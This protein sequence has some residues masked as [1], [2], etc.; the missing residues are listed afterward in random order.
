[1]V[2]HRIVSGFV[3]QAGE[4]TAA[5]ANINVPQINNEIVSSLRYTSDGVL[6][7]ARTNNDDTNNSQF[8]ITADTEPFLDYQYTIFGRVVSDPNNL[9]QAMNSVPVDSNSVP[10]SAVTITDAKI[11]QD[12]FDEALQIGVPFGVSSGSGDITVT[13]NDGNGGT[14]SQ[15]F[16]VTIQADQNDPSAFLQNVPNSVTTTANTPTTFQ[17]STFDLHGDTLTYYGPSGLQSS[18]FSN[19]DLSPS[20]TL[21]PNVQ[22]NVNSSTGQVTVTPTNGFVGVAPLWVG[23][24]STTA[25]N[26]EPSTAMIPLFV[27]PAAPSG[28]SLASSSDTG[29]SNSDG[30]TANNNS[31]ASTELSFNVSGVTAGDTIELFDGSTQIFSMVAPSASFTL[32][33]DGSHTLTGR[34]SFVFHQASRARLASRIT[35]SATPAAR[36]CW[37]VRRPPLYL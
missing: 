37:P 20:Q 25:L 16:H 26:T 34:G 5:D 8:F 31:S 3:D 2:F 6:G 36:R 12:P 7:M 33:T 14:A 27:D 1:M 4:P 21:N 9:V 19:L 22:I 28:F 32:R 29:S 11:I 24:N 18:Q 23:V 30:L 13:A 35:R 17:L 15:T 10:D